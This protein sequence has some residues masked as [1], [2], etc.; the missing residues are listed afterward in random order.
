MKTDAEIRGAE[1]GPVQLPVLD[2]INS[3]TV[4]YARLTLA[5]PWGILAGILRPLD[6]HHLMAL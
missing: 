1:A 2:C 4:C 3:R 5:A 6:I